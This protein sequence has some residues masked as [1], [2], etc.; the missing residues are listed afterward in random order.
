M[1]RYLAGLAAIVAAVS[2]TSPAFAADSELMSLFKRLCVQPG[3]AMA[4]ALAKADAEGWMKV[5]EGTFSGDEFKEMTS[6]DARF[7]VEGEGFKM[8][9]VG[10]GELDTELGKTTVDICFVASSKADPIATK[11]ETQAFARVQ[12]SASMS[13]GNQTMWFY[14]DGRNGRREAETL[15]DA[16]LRTAIQTRATRFVLFQTEPD[17]VMVGYAI[18]RI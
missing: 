14:T 3:A 18:P 7:H 13:V 1:N 10:V 5:P 12:P 6:M 4:P 8:I 11:A 17:L 9:F 15:P 2:L 16:E